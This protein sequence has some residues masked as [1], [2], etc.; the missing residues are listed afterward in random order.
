MTQTPAGIIM[1]HSEIRYARIS[2]NATP[3]I[4]IHSQFA[5]HQN[6]LNP[7]NPT[8]TIP[9]A[10]PTESKIKIEVFNLLGQR[11]AILEDGIM[12]AGYHQAVWDGRSSSGVS[13][14]SGLYLL[15][16]EAAGTVK[17]MKFTG[18]R[19]LMLLK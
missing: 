13:V 12:Q 9:F 10:L 7:F 19:K 14:A 4:E 18:T 16:I 15:K 17:E 6:Y 2:F 11:V 8:T 1:I 3:D 5:L